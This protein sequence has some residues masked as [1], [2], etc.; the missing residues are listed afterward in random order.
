M[1]GRIAGRQPGE[2][3]VHGAE[4]GATAGKM[5]TRDRVPRP[6]RMESPELQHAVSGTTRAGCGSLC[7]QHQPCRGLGSQNSS[8]PP[9]A[10]LVL[11]YLQDRC[12]FPVEGPVA[13]QKAVSPSP[14][15][16][17]SPRS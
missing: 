8:G 3:S 5:G 6:R 9:G 15:K 16:A 4:G 17:M 12:Q 11:L 7:P 13:A 14:G 10:A 1:D 2:G